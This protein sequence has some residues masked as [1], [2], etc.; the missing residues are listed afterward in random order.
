M[1]LDE[2]IL[3]NERLGRVSK[4]VHL[5]KA[6][7]KELIESYPS[8]VRQ[9]LNKT[10]VKVK[11]ELPSKVLYAIVVKHLHKN[12]K[13]RDAM[14]KMLLE[15]D[16]FLHADGKWVG[17]V[18]AGLSA[19]GSVLSGIG[20]GQLQNTPDQLALQQQQME[21]EQQRRAEEERRRSRNLLILGGIIVA[22]IGAYFIIKAIKAKQVQ[23]ELNIAS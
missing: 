22:V 5:V 23:T 15:M 13:L 3:E 16:G 6:R 21:L 1:R 18:G 4:N 10:D 11:T 17:I 2:I 19:V 9:V 14:A 20:Q 12:S 7:L 8:E